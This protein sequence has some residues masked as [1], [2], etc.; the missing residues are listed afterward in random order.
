MDDIEVTEDMIEEAPPE[1]SLHA[2]T[3]QKSPKTMQVRAQIFDWELVGLVDSGSTH[4]FLSLMTAQHLQLQILSHPTATVSV[5]NGEKVPSYGISKPVNFT[6]G[7]TLFH[8]E[9]FVIPLAG[10][11]LVLGI[12]WLQTL[13]PILWDFSALTMNF[14]LRGSQVLLQGSHTEAQ[15]HIHSL[16]APDNSAGSIDGMIDEFSDLFYELTWLPPLRQCDHRICL[17]PGSDVV[18]VH[19]Y[20]Y[21]HLQKDEIER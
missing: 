13:G 1:I 9:F 8:A 20:W 16:T 2:I 21:P 15:Q 5:A 17:K 3:G 11:D 6:T 7:T 18:V 12:K 14:V 19:S 4:N 10:F